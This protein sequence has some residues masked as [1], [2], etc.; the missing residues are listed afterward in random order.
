M[1]FSDLPPDL[2]K[3]RK[4]NLGCGYFP[5]KEYLNVDCSEVYEPD[6]LHDLDVMPWPFPD[7]HY[8]L[9]ELDHVLEHLTDVAAVLGELERALAP[10]GTL[11]IRVPHFS[12]GHTH[13]DHKHGFDFSFMIYFDPR[14]SGGF[15]K[16]TL[17]PLRTRFT[18][19][20]QPHLKR[21]HLGPGSY[22]VGSVL[23]RL[24]DFIGNLNL[25]FTSR[26]FCFW[27][28]GYDEISFTLRKPV[29]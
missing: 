18:W 10:G 26:L 2:Q 15:E 12:R 5:K 11:I 29:H 20:A 28:G 4:L 6:L 17:V 9:I 7:A 22:F 25:P 14:T 16:S 23:G 1:T 8:E 21:Q 27:V 24:F 3:R 13:W 19:F